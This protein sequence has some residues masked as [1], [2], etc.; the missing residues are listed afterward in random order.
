MS[1]VSLV[2]RPAVDGTGAD[3][4]FI[5]IQPDNGAPYSI[6][7]GLQEEGFG[8]LDRA[9]PLVQEPYNY[10]APYYNSA[11]QFDVQPPPG[12]DHETFVNYLNAVAAEYNNAAGYYFYTQNSNSYAYTVLNDSGARYPRKGDRPPGDGGDPDKR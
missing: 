10:D 4:A 12:M 3:H 2:L 7:G 6:S 8:V 11:L 5:L 1:S 9:T